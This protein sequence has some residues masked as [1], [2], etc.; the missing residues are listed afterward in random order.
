MSMCAMYY[1]VKWPQTGKTA[2]KH[3]HSGVKMFNRRILWLIELFDKKVV[4]VEQRT[5]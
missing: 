2:R 1:N 5:Q 4:Q 3:N